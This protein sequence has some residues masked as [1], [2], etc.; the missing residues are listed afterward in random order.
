MRAAFNI[1]LYYE[2]KDNPRTGYRNGWVKQIN[3]RNQVAE[4]KLLILPF[5]Y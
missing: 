3:W 4:M 5:I 1:A 2:M